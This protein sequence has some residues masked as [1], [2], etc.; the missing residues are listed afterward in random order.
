MHSRDELAYYAERARSERQQAER[1]CT[2][3]VAKVHLQLAERYESLIAKRLERG[4]AANDD[5]IS[6]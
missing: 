6:E 4:L 2:P 3:A 5:Y 1:A